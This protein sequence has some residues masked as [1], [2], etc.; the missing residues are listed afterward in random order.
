VEQRPILVT[1]AHRSGT[2]WV[3]KM[4]AASGQAA[5]ISEP[6]NVS[7]RR[8]VLAAPVER[9]YTYI[10]QQN[11]DA[12]LPAFRNLLHYDYHLWSEL[13]SLRSMKDL[14][15]MGRDSTTFL[16]G[17]IQGLRPLLKDPFAV[18]STPWFARMLNC[19]VVVVVRRPAAVASSLKRLE[20][21]FD[22][23]DLLD[24]PL[25][26]RDWLEPFREEMQATGKEPV[27]LIQQSSLLWKMIYTV[28]HQHR[29]QIP[30][31]TLVRHEDLSL[32]P[33]SGFQ[34]LYERLGLNFSP[35]ARQAIIRSS[36]P[37]NPRELSRKAVH[38]VQ[39]DSRS[40]LDNWKR[41]LEPDEIQM[42]QR[43]TAPLE[44]VYYPE[45]DWD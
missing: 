13:K 9:W 5:Y 20:W 42:V 31:V 11:Q 38:A 17:R 4:L 37:D 39:L 8:G 34:S 44:K 1:G 23:R 33:L 2:T 6:L 21:P 14:L 10:C 28:V 7:H 3:G 41:R 24:Q 26:M 18:F 35:R 16:R 30:D 12:Y 29:D 45:E 40:N 27:S 15:R 32:E 19:Q 43:I 36:Q 25:L 22:I